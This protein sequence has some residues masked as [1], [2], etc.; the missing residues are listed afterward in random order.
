MELGFVLFAAATA[1][2]KTNRIGALKNAGGCTVMYFS[3]E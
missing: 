2:K 3:W 1:A